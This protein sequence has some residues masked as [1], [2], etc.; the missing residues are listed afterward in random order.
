V[1]LS[2]LEYRLPPSAIAQAPAEPREAARLLLVDRA[3]GALSDHVFR[4]LPELLRPGDCVV[5]NDSRVIPARVF[6]EDD[7]GRRIELLF[8]EPLAPERWRALVRPGRR[9]R[10]RAELRTGGAGGAH[11]RVAAVEP[12]GV[13]VIERLDGTIAELLAVH[14]LPPLPP[15]IAR[16][17]KPELEDRDRYQTVYARPA[18]S[19]AAPTAGL[20]FSKELLAQLAQRDIE[21]HR[22]TL[23][24]GPGTFRP[25]KAARVEDH[26][27]PPERALVSADTAF[28][29]NLALADGRRVVAVG[30]T[31]TRTLESAVDS[32]GVVRPFDGHAS[33]TIHPGYR[34]RVVDALVTNFHLPR[35]SLLS[36][37]VAF[38]GR[39][40][41]LRAYE[42]AIETGYR[43]YSYGD[44]M[45]I[46][47]DVGGSAA[48]PPPP[49]SD[50]RGSAPLP[51][52][53][54]SAEPPSS[55]APVVSSGP[56]RRKSTTSRRRTR[57]AGR[58]AA[59]PP[60][61]ASEGQPNRPGEA[62]SDAGREGADPAA[63]MAP[64]SHEEAP[65]EGAGDGAADAGGDVRSD[66]DARDAG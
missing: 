41:V 64:T 11:L 51:P 55:S 18:G 16:H 57:R 39:D 13:R 12:D 8:V 37:V 42:H 2:E 45:L 30:T 53:P 26:V 34:F 50:V 5:V 17:E 54:P 38:A 49:E 23:H 66:P 24:V 22:V 1:D 35:S 46:L 36:L 3:T 56:R 44:A 4:D 48:L 60:S 62:V 43:F 7:G 21:V 61:A 20:H 28:A 58:S 9:C 40:V 52:T 19:I 14:G 32:V 25:I 63:G 29:V 47:K 15:Y 6:A 59:A 27:V 33:L 31:A 10:A 65:R